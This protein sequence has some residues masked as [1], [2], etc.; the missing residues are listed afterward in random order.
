[1][2]HTASASLAYQIRCDTHTHTIFSRHAYSTLE[3]NCRK[4]CDLGFELLGVSDHFSS[5]LFEQQTLKNFQHFLNME[6]WP[7]MYGDLR[8]LKACEVDIEDASGS[9]FGERI[10]L[11]HHI[12]GR[13]MKHKHSLADLV[14]SQC[15][16][17]IASVHDKSF[18]YDRTPSQ[19]AQ[20]YIR[21]LE[22]PK[23]QFDSAVVP[24]PK[25][26]R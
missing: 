13:A 10:S 3:E 22:R 6:I 23:A 18:S 26:I 19:N 16:Y 17:L 9:L 2:T 5:M 7:E 1:M 25:A 8:L 14:F 24:H 12:T 20:T 4:A 11:T 21:A 15:D